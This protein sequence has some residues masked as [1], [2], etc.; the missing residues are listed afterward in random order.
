MFGGVSFE[1]A[2]TPTNYLYAFRYISNQW[3]RLPPDMKVNS[4]RTKVSVQSY[5]LINM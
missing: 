3:F 1:M 5:H 2:V 4:I